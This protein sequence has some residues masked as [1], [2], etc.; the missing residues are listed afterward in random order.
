[1]IE[2]PK[3]ETENLKSTVNISAGRDFS[4]NLPVKTCHI[5]LVRVRISRGAVTQKWLGFNRN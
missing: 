3:R 5:S 4:T 1:L 2:K